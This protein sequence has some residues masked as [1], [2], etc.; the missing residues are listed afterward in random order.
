MWKKRD[1]SKGAVK[2]CHH[3]TVTTLA[4]G[5]GWASGQALVVS[6]CILIRWISEMS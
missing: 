3:I 2:I 5:V 4:K 6:Q 1:D